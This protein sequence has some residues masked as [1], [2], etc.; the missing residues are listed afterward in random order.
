MTLT[1]EEYAACAAQAT[2]VM[3][4]PK[5]NLPVGWGFYYRHNLKYLRAYYAFGM[6]SN[7]SDIPDDRTDVFLGMIL[8][9]SAHPRA[10]RFT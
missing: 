6:P 4:L 5:R 3:N 1:D 7:Y 2:Q 9:Q 10:I 8:Y